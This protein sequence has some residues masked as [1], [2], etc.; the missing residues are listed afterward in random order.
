MWTIHLKNK[1][2]QT[3]T[4]EISNILT[5]SKR[6]PLKIES[7]RGAEFSNSILQ[8]FLKAKNV[9]HYSN[10]TDKRPSI[11]EKVIRT[12]RNMLR[13]P[14]FEKG[15]AEWLSELPS[16]IKKKNNS[17][18]SATKM[19]HI[20]ASEKSN[21]KEVYSNLKDNREVRKP[22]IKLG[23]LVRTS[24]IKKLFAN[25]D[26]THYSFKLYTI[27]EVIHD[28]IPSYRI[29]V[30]PERYNEYPLLPSKLS[31]EQNNEVLKEFSLIQ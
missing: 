24:D 27:T 12:V 21:G 23:N 28:T 2:S 6:S 26:S 22:K 29:D 19:T 10:F 5:K 17:I 15:N 9:Q 7:D 14:V 3:I 31:L 30:L 13:K 1:Y 16:V 8:N 4:Q 25:D 11:A 20:Q 18:H